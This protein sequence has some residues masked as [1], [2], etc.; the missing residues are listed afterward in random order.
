MMMLTIFKRFKAFLHEDRGS[1]AVETMLMVPILA[2]AWMGTLTF[3]DA[4]KHEAVT[5][6]AGLTIADMISRE[7]E[8][9]DDAYIDG[10]REVL[11]YLSKE[12]PQP[13]LR[14]TSFRWNENQ[15]KYVRV[16]SKERGPRSPLKTS[17]LVAMSDIL[18]VMANGER[19]LLIETWTEY[20]PP[21]DIGI[22]AREM[23][24]Y[25]VI[26]PRFVPHICFSNTPEV[27]STLKC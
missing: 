11:V 9:V 1:I 23:Y 15:N 5:F 16:W 27:T 4:Y 22:G 12:D 24:T 10:A 19:A 18:P 7:A 2:W 26:S 20:V 3:F 6:K 25:N 17:D 14:I 21:W 8:A 13:D